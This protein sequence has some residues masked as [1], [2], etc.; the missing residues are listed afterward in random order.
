MVVKDHRNNGASYRAQLADVMR[1]AEA[2]ESHA[3]DES[4]A[5]A[6]DDP[7]RVMWAR[8]ERRYATVRGNAHHLLVIHDW[9]EQR[10]KPLFRLRRYL[11]LL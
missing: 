4:N 11:N 7:Q 6:A 3:R 2:L 5:L 9:T 8:I 1:R 10:R